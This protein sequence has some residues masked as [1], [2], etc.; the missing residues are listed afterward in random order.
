MRIADIGLSNLSFRRRFQ[1][2]V[3]LVVLISII[4]GLTNWTNFG[5]MVNQN[6]R[7]EELA[8]AMRH[9]MH[10]DMM[11]DA[12][13]GDVLTARLAAL[14]ADAAG[15]AVARDSLGGHFTELRNSQDAIADLAL[16]TDVR[17]EMALLRDAWTAYITDAE[18]AM[19]GLA[20]DS[21]RADA[22]IEKFN[23]QAELV[24]TTMAQ[25]TAMLE[26]RMGDEGNRVVAIA[27][28]SELLIAV[29][30]LLM[31]LLLTGA[32]WF[33]QR[34]L[35]LPVVNAS[36]ALIDLSNG[37]DIGDVA[38]TARKDEIGDLARGIS[39]FK[40]KAEQVAAA[41]AA[42][43]Q[44]ESQAKS[45]AA[46]AVR[47]N[48]RREAL[49]R[50]AVSL[51]TRVLTAAEAVAKTARTLQQASLA[52]ETAAQ[53]T[54]G[55]LTRASATGTQMVSNVDEVAAATQQLAT[56]AQEIGQQMALAVGQIDTAASMGAQ[57]AAQTNQLNTLAA[58]IDTI[59]TFIAD[60]AR[61]TNLLALN[62]AIEAARA[63]AAGRG[64][65]VVADEVKS[66][67]TETAQ[68]AG[69]IATQI[70]A[71]RTLA[72]NVVSAFAQVN[73]AVGHMQQAS[74]AVASSVDEQ[75]M[76]T[77]AIAGNVQEVA[78]GTRGLGANMASVDIIAGEVDA[79]ARALVAAARD[80]DRLSTN[81][82][83][84]VSQVI[85]EVRAA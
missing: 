73:A 60:I 18:Q 12:I 77:V 81:L 30:P 83:S 69:K 72:D 56:S 48:D 57:A 20:A 54:R 43:R 4:F 74:I 19:A 85:A 11:H 37:R 61:Q 75:G 1:I 15:I 34:T 80:L 40:A 42:Q 52:V 33:A 44:A 58:G 13:L 84:D 10:A 41:L 5:A 2:G 31:M 14:D 3:G 78:L 39:A 29:Q 16:P 71:V 79:Q 49:V 27:A 47:E 6:E 35:I 36:R 26:T 68:A 59:S 46:R 32:A 70:S 28:R 53:D 24:E 65:A 67:A 55:Q 23:G 76:A 7:A 82:T 50:L 9:H 38:G 17:R 22:L 8:T 25:S 21:P 64:F 62:A 63:G 66:L 51:E 45:E